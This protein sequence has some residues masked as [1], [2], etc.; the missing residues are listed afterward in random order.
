MAAMIGGERVMLAHGSGGRLSQQLTQEIFLR[1][2]DSPVLRRLDDFA[3]LDGRPGRFAFTTDSF[4]VKPIFF[5][6]GDI[7]KLAVCGTVNDLSMSG[8]VPKYLSAT[9]IIEE[10]FFI[11]DLLKI[12][13]SM[14]RVAEEAGVEIVA[15]DTKVVE[16]GK[17][18]GIFITTTGLGIIPQGI[19]ISGAG[20]RPGDKIVLSGPIGDH[21]IAILSEREGF[22]FKAEMQ[23]DCA[24]LNDLV[25]AMLEVSADIHCL[26]DPTR[27]GLATVLNEVAGQSGVGMRIY[28]GA[29]PVRDA[30]RAA[31]ELLG[32]DPLYV[33]N[34]GKLVAVVGAAVADAIVDRMRRHDYGR[35]AVIIG[36]VLEGPIGCVT[37][38]TKIGG[39]RVI[40]M[41]AGEMLP[42]IC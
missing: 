7:G 25:K 10:G 37:M 1:A 24:P 39:T 40:D 18:D 35:E 19:G 5:T 30:V 20:A 3:V 21:G 6:G 38:A 9:F 12:A 31:C 2:F 28:E 17:A 32:Y 29:V 11:A 27:G 42:R 34:E 8:A 36:E 15:G 4:V 26:R 33:A 23:S 14:Q 16:V 13:Q 41:L 22:R